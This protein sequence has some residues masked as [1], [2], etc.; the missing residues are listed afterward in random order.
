M[1]PCKNKGEDARL[2]E[3]VE[4]VSDFAC[5]LG[6]NIP[7]GKDSLSMTQKYPE[8]K[9]VKSPGTVIIS[10]VGEV[11]DINKVIEPSVKPIKFSWLIYINLSQD[12]AKLGGSSFAQVLNS[13]GTKVPTITN[14]VYFKKVFDVIQEAIMADEILAGHDVSDGGIITTLLEMCFSTPEVGLILSPNDL[15]GK[16]LVEQLFNE[17][18]GVIVQVN[19]ELLAHRLSS[20]GIAFNELAV[21]NFSRKITMDDGL[22]LDIDELRDTWYKS[23]YLLDQH[24]TGKELAKERFDNY[25]LQPLSYTFND[26][27]TGKLA[28]LGLDK[29]HKKSNA[30]AAI[31]R[32]KGV[33]GDR[34]MAHALY[35]AGFE[36]KDVHMT[37]LISGRETLEGINMIVF[38]GGFSNSDVLGSAKGWAGAFIYNPKAKEVLDRFYARKDT[39]SL[40]V[41]NGC[42]LMMELGLVYDEKANHPKM[43][44]NESHKF[45]SG[46]VTMSIPENNS[47]MLSSLEGSK[48]GVWVAHGEG[49]FKLTTAQASKIV[50]TYSYDTYPGN[51]N[52]SDFS[53][54]AVCSANGRH[55]A[56][57]PHL[58]R[59]IFPWN[60][61]YYTNKSDEVTPWVEAFVNARKWVENHTN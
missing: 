43:T 19:D 45:E 36:V 52:G 56:M 57:M 25:K 6:I 46:F 27:F 10:A 9:S 14:P 53:A 3:A 59:S 29:T 31:I 15:S 42:Q 38:V 23:S 55:L 47:V 32:E 61:P 24:Q 8:G 40:G 48:L 12:K 21:L 51:P 13:I 33:N 18:P 60:W 5:E 34:E 54:A 26:S 37:D 58:E 17:N 11:T 30:R 7:T 1:W 20:A 44:H 49:K 28:Q 50:G 41:C 39:L 35:L 22:T 2:Y 16:D 4:A